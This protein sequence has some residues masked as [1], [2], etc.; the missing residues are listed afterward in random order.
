MDLNIKD[1]IKGIMPAE[2]S[3]DVEEGARYRWVLSSEKKLAYQMYQESDE[4]VPFEKIIHILNKQLRSLN[5][6][7]PKLQVA[8]SMQLRQLRSMME[9]KIQAYLEKNSSCIGRIRLIWRGIWNHGHI[10]NQSKKIFKKLD[11]LIK[12]PQAPDVTKLDTFLKLIVPPCETMQFSLISGLVFSQWAY[13]PLVDV[14]QEQEYVEHTDGYLVP[15][16]NLMDG[17]TVEPSQLPTTDLNIL[18]PVMSRQLDAFKE[19]NEISPMQKLRLKAFQAL[20]RGRAIEASDLKTS[21]LGKIERLLACPVSA[22]PSAEEIE[23][24]NA[25]KIRIFQELIATEEAHRIRILRSVN[26]LIFFL[27]LSE[28]SGI[29]CSAEFSMFFRGG[30]GALKPYQARLTDCLEAFKNLLGHIDQFIFVLKEVEGMGEY[31]RVAALQDL[32]NSSN[33]TDYVKATSV[34]A[35]YY[36]VLSMFRK[37]IK[38]KNPNNQEVVEFF[39]VHEQKLD[40][41]SDFIASGQRLPRLVLLIE[42][43][44]ENSVYNELDN[45]IYEGYVKA[46]IRIYSLGMNFNKRLRYMFVA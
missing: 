34:A 17:V 31:E 26:H 23:K 36:D 2:I 37:D 21:I 4:N 39:S 35:R 14:I 45:Q 5:D 30:E 38:E 32:L 7:Y 27:G 22:A 19:L 20:V 29:S 18:L 42:G 1:F 41:C 43:L 16:E 33:Y 13:D 11:A 12:K 44:L 15:L 8:D 25:K 6:N 3:L 46:W 10:R 24:M 28:K 40:I 9:S